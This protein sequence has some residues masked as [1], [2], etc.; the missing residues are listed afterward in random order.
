MSQDRP[1]LLD[2]IRGLLEAKRYAV[3]G[4]Q[5]EQGVML[6]LMAFG[7]SADL[8]TFTVATD[9]ATAKYANLQRTPR[10]AL[11]V[12]NRSNRGSDSGTALALTIEGMAEE[13]MGDELV[14]NAAR[15]LARHPQMSEFI[16]APGCA[17]FRI[18]VARYELVRGLSDV[19]E[20][21]PG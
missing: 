18:M 6:N 5:G 3:L 17:I 12:D 9:R 21:L 8:R 20:W 7:F 10:A 15:L 2:A 16:N 14:Q 1:P 11:L 13:L 4:T 19:E